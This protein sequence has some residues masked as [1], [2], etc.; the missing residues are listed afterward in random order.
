MADQPC[1]AQ[2]CIAHVHMLC[3]L[4]AKGRLTCAVQLVRICILSLVQDRQQLMCIV[5]MWHALSREFSGCPV[6]L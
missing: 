6:M 3:R 5:K 2:N 4:C 1:H